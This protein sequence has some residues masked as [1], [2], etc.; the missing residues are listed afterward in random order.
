MIEFCPHVGPILGFL[1]LMYLISVARSG[2]S[3]NGLHR[4]LH[5]KDVL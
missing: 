4:T 2:L 3:F 1:R 5:E